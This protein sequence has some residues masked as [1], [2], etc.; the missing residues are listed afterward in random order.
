MSILMFEE[1]YLEDGYPKEGCICPKVGSL[2]AWQSPNS[3]AMLWWGSRA[4][5]WVRGMVL[6]VRGC[7]ALA[8]CLGSQGQGCRIWPSSGAG[9]AKQQK[10]L[11]VSLMVSAL[12]PREGK[13]ERAPVCDVR[14]KTW[15]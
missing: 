9:E 14:D 12:E 10:K 2:P 13:G 7:R 8:P 3:P 15:G 4:G 6:M 5:V 1:L 11:F